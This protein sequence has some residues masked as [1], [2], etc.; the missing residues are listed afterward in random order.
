VKS[1]D[2]VPLARTVQE[3][4][5]AAEKRRATIAR[6]KEEAEQA[7]LDI[8]A[9]QAAEDIERQELADARAEFLAA[10]RAA[11]AERQADVDAALAR[12]RQA[13]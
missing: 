1:A 3:W 10:H 2:T 8:E 4:A 9:T 13:I 7:A 11:R 5:A 12:F 6:Q